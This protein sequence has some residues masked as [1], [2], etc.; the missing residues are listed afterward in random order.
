MTKCRSKRNAEERI[1]KLKALIE[2][3][4]KGVSMLDRN[5][6]SVDAAFRRFSQ[7]TNEIAETINGYDH[8]P[9]I[10]YLLNR[11]QIGETDNTPEQQSALLARYYEKWGALEDALEAQGEFDSKW[12][13]GFDAAIL[14]RESQK[15][16]QIGK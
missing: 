11:W 3:W 10:E 2:R 6:I 16:S 4:N 15:T 12:R 7:L 9:E 14:S 5:E 13:E 1:Q 8:V